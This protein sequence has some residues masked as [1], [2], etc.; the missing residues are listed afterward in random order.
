MA[1]AGEGAGPAAERAPGMD[2]DLPRRYNP[3][4]GKPITKE[5]PGAWMLG[6]NISDSDQ[7]GRFVQKLGM[8]HSDFI[9]QHDSAEANQLVAKHMGR[10]LSK[11]VELDGFKGLR[12]DY[13]MKEIHEGNWTQATQVELLRKY[14]EPIRESAV[15]QAIQEDKAAFIKSKT[16]QQP[17]HLRESIR[18]LERQRLF[19]EV[20]RKSRNAQP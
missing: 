12:K 14:L 6:A 13:I 1:H 5:Y 19:E 20:E 10:I 11:P 3:T 15:K 9:G 4:T 8:T 7:F 18:R 2:K 17:I 16:S